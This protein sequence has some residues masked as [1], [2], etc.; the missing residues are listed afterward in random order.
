MSRGAWRRASRGRR[1]AEAGAF[2][3]V[4]DEELDSDSARAQLADDRNCGGRAARDGERDKGWGD[5][6]R[7]RRDDAVDGGELG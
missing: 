5:K 4:L 3:G 2:N 7:R 1:T 6:R